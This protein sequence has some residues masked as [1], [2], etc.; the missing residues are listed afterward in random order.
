MG[1]WNGWYHVDGCTYGAWLRGDKRGWRSRKHRTHSPGDYKDPPPPGTHE[2]L[3]RRS[4]EL[5]KG[6]PVVLSV[7]QRRIAGQA[8]VEMPAR[9]SVELLSLSLGG[10]HYHILARF[11]HLGARAAVG[12]A[13]KHAYHVLRDHGREQTGSVWAKR[14]RPSPVRD[15]RHQVNVYRYI[16]DHAKEGAWPWSHKQGLYWRD[17]GTTP[18]TDG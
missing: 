11:G 3:L 15:R 16:L 7:P 10:M 1:A 12:R 13:K 18:G 17:D 5:M 4:R 14:C 8:L 6:E 2:T 9:Q